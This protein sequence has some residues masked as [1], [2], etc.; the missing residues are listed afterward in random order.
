MT[1]LMEAKRR[2]LKRPGL[3][4]VGAVAVAQAHAIIVAARDEPGVIAPGAANGPGSP[5][6]VRASSVVEAEF[7]QGVSV[8]WSQRS[9]LFRA[10]F[11]SHR[12]GSSSSEQIG[13][14]FARLRPG[15]TPAR[16]RRQCSGRVVARNRACPDPR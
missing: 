12:T 5:E 6:A 10:D 7:L 15:K 3:T 8:S 13:P 2:R 14:V 9:T 16:E 1:V 4:W 11:P